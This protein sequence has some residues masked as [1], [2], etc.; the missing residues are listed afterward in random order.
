MFRGLWLWLW[1]GGGDPDAVPFE[2]TTLRLV[3]SDAAQAKTWS[4][5]VPAFTYDDPSD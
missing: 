2:P 4:D 3:W 1:A 5:A